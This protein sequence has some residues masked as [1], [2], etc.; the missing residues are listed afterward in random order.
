[1]ALAK[2]VLMITQEE[3]RRY[4]VVRKI[5]DR[6]MN[7]QEAAEY[8]DLSDRQIRRI[9][10]RVRKEG[11]RGVIH[12]LRGAK[13]CRRLPESFKNRI[14]E[15]YRR[16]YAD[17][18][19]TLASEKLLERDKVKVCDETLRRWL[20]QAG[21][22]RLR[23]R[24]KP[25]ERS[26]RQRKEHVGEMVQLDGSHHDWLEGRG[27]KLV[28]MGYIDDATSRFYG[29]FYGYEGTLPAM[30]SLKRYI[31]L[32]G[33]PRSIYLD[34]HSTYKNN[35]KQRYT[36]W[37]F[38]DQGELTQ[39]ARACRQLGTELIYAHSAPAKGRVERVF[40]TLQDRLV[41]ELRLSGAKTC[42]EANV[43]LGWYLNVFNRKF[44]VSARKKGD[45]HRPLNPRMDLDEILSVQTKR[46]L[47]ND[48]TIFHNKRWFQVLTKTRAQNVM[49]HEYLSGRMGVKG[50]MA[51]LS[52]QL[53][54]GP[55]S[56]IQQNNRPH[57]IRKRRRPYIPP[58]ESYWRR[59][60]TLL[61]AK[62]N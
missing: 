20:I 37:P 24:K 52:Y 14:L 38:R 32:Y 45:W 29:R 61:Y 58:K 43:V 25:K 55:P 54:E 62:P 30:G 59:S 16:Q 2:D 17:F 1:M 49:I 28:L 47:R 8:L 27:P 39:F 33:I 22:W 26:W 35:H 9:V 57:N 40:R 50:G 44:R 46:V 42:Q 13:G 18:G 6:E 31:K 23:Q 51:R 4:Q 21:L 5:F 34:K 11:E 7:Q 48:R 12:R 3:V 41:K 53:I 19:P 60:S 56:R 36:D 10:S 15:V